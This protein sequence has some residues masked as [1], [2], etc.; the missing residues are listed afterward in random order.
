MGMRWR[1]D[2]HDVDVGARDGHLPIVCR[3]RDRKAGCERFGALRLHIREHDNLG[4]RFADPARNMGGF[5][6]FSGAEDGDAKLLVGHAEDGSRNALRGAKFAPK[7]APSLR[8]VCAKFT[9]SLRQVCAKFTPSL[10]QVCAKF[11]N[12]R[13]PPIM[14]LAPGAKVMNDTSSSESFI[15]GLPKAELHIHIEGSLEPELMF[16]ISKRND[17]ALPFATV[18]EVRNAYAFDDLQ[19]FLDVYYRGASVLVHEQDF[20]ELA[21]AYLKKAASQNVRHTEIFFDPQTHTDRA[22]HSRPSFEG[23]G[24]RSTKP[25]E[26]GECLPS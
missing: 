21:F 6:P 19:S 14:E 18:E 1:H 5:G 8:Q 3:F 16:E 20:Y 26:R 10:R 24:G 9:P 4:A 7:F 13:L 2:I 23:S 25:R 17:V 22:S 12:A 15:R 11:T